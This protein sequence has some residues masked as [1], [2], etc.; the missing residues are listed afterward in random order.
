M[1]CPM[2]QTQYLIGLEF[3]P[4]HPFLN[5][6]SSDGSVLLATAIVHQKQAPPIL[7]ALN[8]GTISVSLIN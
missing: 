4:C 1:S 8:G 3:Q 6:T 5:C 2:T 7:S